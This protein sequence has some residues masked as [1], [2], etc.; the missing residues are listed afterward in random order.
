MKKNILHLILFLFL[1]FTG[2][3][4][5]DFHY[6]QFYNEPLNFNPSLAGM[7][8]GDKRFILSL[9][10]Q[11]RSI[12]VPYSTFSLNYDMKFLPQ[13][14]KKGFFSAGVI[15]NYDR[16]G[17][18]ALTLYNLNLAGSYTYYLTPQHLISGGGLIGFS[19]RGFSEDNLSWDNYW[20]PVR[21][22]VDPT[23]GSGEPFER[24][25]FSFLETGAGVNYRFQHSVRNSL[26]LGASAFHLT[27]PSQNF[28]GVTVDPLDIRLSLMA[29]ANVKLT[30]E[31]DIQGQ[32]LYQKQ[33]VYKET[34]LGGFIKLYINNKLGKQLSL[35]LGLMNRFGEGIAPKIAVEYNSWYVGLNYDVVT[36]K[37]LS[38]YSNYRGGPEIHLKYVIKN[39]K[40]FGEFKI[41]PIY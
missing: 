20:D 21:E 9:R 5:Q 24:Y 26:M 18:S 7:Y 33:D 15:F 36:K 10:D 30:K 14:P 29:I 12:P 2:L 17:S 1:P 3:M 35:N 8:D 11:Y 38:E 4:A 27:Q 41:C 28:S 16:Q 37:D 31:L 13:R 34:V 19:N 22:T 25:R 39:V 32:F 6:S 40:P 23:L